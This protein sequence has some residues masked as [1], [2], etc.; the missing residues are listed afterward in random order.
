MRYQYKHLSIRDISLLYNSDILRVW[1]DVHCVVEKL[2][3]PQS[4]SFMQVIILINQHA[5]IFSKNSDIST[6]LKLL[7]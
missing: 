7:I 5:F 1:S 6:M 2:M 3:I 4:V